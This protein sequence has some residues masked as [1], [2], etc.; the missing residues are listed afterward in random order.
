MPPGSDP[1]YCVMDISR[2]REELGYAPQFV[3]PEDMVRDYIAIAERLG[4][5]ETASKR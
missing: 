1:F 4:L 5:A 2:A 3:E